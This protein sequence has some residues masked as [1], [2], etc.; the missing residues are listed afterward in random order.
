MK[1]LTNSILEALDNNT[2]VFN[3]VVVEFIPKRSYNKPEGGV[4]FELPAGASKETIQTYI[5]QCIVPY[6]P[7]GEKNKDAQ[8]FLGNNFSAITDI[9]LTWDGEETDKSKFGNDHITAPVKFDTDF[10][11]EYSE[12]LEEVLLKDVKVT[13][14]FSQFTIEGA[15]DDETEDEDACTDLLAGEFTDLADAEHRSK[16]GLMFDQVGYDDF[17]ID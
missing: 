7:G 14:T 1:S 13:L 4:V 12:K 16:F 9:N 17:S 10:G 2:V 8:K 6:L 11:V 15:S 5:D 3:N